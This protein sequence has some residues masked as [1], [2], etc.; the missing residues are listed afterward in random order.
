MRNRADLT[1]RTVE[2]IADLVNAHQMW[3]TD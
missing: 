3:F 1:D 2:Q